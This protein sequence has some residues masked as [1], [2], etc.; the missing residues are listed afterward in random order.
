MSQL[1]AVFI[2]HGA[3]DL[4]LRPSPA[5]DFLRGLGQQIE[6]PTAI[7]VIS[8]HWETTTPQVS[9][10]A[11]PATIYDFTGFSSELY[12]L[13]YPAPGAPQLAQRVNTLLT[14]AGFARA[15][16][17]NRGLDHG[18]WNPLLLIY[19]D[20][21]IRVT[22]LSI[23]PHQ[24]AAYHV[25]LGQA[26]APLR[27][28]GGLILASGSITH[29]LREIG[30]YA[31]DITPPAWVSDFVEWLTAQVAAGDTDALINYRQLAP[32]ADRNH[33]SPEHLL[34][35]FVALGA[36]GSATT[37]SQLHASYT[38]GILSMAAFSFP[39]WVN[40]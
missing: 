37:G 31:A 2:S 8:A 17:P 1:P 20:A 22:Q 6:T 32:F 36:S 28:E 7:L 24:D 26:I 18:A 23:Q 16:V 14:E 34:P 29:N 35:F 38:Y 11:L 4:P 30:R 19:P 12:Q 21:D 10:A 25:R 39:A 13:T 33:P 5:R 40:R 9:A 15:V 27:D 3:P